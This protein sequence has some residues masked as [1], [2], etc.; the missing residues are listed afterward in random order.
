MRP[1]FTIVG[2]DRLFTLGIDFSFGFE[3]QWGIGLNLGLFA[4]YVGLARS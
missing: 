2:P 4:V 1:F 3:G